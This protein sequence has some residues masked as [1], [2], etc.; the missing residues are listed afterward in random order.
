M[1]VD[2]RHIGMFLVEGQD[3]I[4]ILYRE[5]RKC[6]RDHIGMFTNQFFQSGIIQSNDKIVLAILDVLQ[7][8]LDRFILDAGI[9][10]VIGIKK[11]DV[12]FDFNGEFLC[13]I[14]DV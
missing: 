1:I 4:G 13:F 6:F 8:C 14:L 12:P 11:D 5:D 2:A 7:F 9:D 3:I 10:L